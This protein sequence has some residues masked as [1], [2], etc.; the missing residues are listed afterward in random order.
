MTPC[1]PKSV[2]VPKTVASQFHDH[3]VVS[4]RL[5]HNSQLIHKVLW[6]CMG[7]KMLLLSTSLPD[8]DEIAGVNRHHWADIFIVR[9]QGPDGWEGSRMNSTALSLT[10]RG[11]GSI[12]LYLARD[13]PCDDNKQP[14]YTG[15]VAAQVNKD[16]AFRHTPGRRCQVCYLCIIEEDSRK[17]QHHHRH[18]EHKDFKS[19]K[20]TL[21][22]STQNGQVQMEHPWTL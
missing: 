14:Y 21:G 12:R 16:R 1:F 11:M 5:I 10:W 22:T 3:K 2:P 6:T 17:R 7:R 15:S 9:R 18:M 19:C 8:M 4:A 13:S 20:E